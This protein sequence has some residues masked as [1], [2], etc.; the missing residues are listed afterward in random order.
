LRHNFRSPSG[1]HALV[2]VATAAPATG[3]PRA[4]R[5]DSWAR[6]GLDFSVAALLL[7]ALLPLVLALAI[8]IRVESRGPSFYRASRVGR[9]QRELRMLKFRK[10]H[11][12]AAGSPLTSPDDERF[13]RMGRL[14]ARTKLDELPQ[15]WH[16]VKGEMSLVGPRPE[17]PVFVTL[18]NEYDLILRVRPGITGLSQLA[19]ARESE[20]LDTTNRLE[21]YQQRVLPQKMRLDSLY[22][23]R[24][25]I[26]LN[27]RVLAWTIMAV[28]LRREVA[29]NRVNGVLTLRRRQREDAS[30]VHTDRFDSAPSVEQA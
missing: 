3:R 29:V 10:M 23:E 11:D 8:A 25:S 24:A 26:G 12:D 5:L 14:L 6:R 17:D 28:V 9:G 2:S 27:L 22:A 18:H 16:V 20:I 13:T 7:L 4:A 30:A 1:V 15:L 19:F 21:H